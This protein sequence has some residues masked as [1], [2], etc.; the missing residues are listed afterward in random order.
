MGL[1][2]ALSVTVCDLVTVTS[3]CGLGSRTEDFSAAGLAN[4]LVKL[5]DSKSIVRP[6]VPEKLQIREEGT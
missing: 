6:F 1:F 4:E 3:D 5:L 2:K